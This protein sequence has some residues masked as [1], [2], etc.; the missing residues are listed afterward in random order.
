M[1]Y[2]IVTKNA[3]L[4]VEG[5][6]ALD[7]IYFSQWKLSKFMNFKDFPY[8]FQHSIQIDFGALWKQRLPMDVLSTI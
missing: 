8:S 1:E 4:D 7:S 6:S 2:D 3:S 5:W